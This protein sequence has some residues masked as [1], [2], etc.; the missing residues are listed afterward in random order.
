MANHYKTVQ[1]LISMVCLSVLVGPVLAQTV[2]DNKK[3]RANAAERNTARASEAE[4]LQAQR[5]TFATS[6]LTSLAD[7]ARSFNDLALRPRVLARAAD[8]LWDADSETARTLFRRAWEAAEKGDA[9]GVTLKTKDSPPPMVIALRRM[10]G[11]DLRS[12]VLGLVAGRD[13]ALAE[14]FLARL[15]ADAKRESE[16]LKSDATA[17]NTTDSWSGSEA[18]A[19]R[20]QMAGRLLDA[21][22]IERSLEFAA[23]VLGQ[24]NVNSISF[25]STLRAKEPGAAA[26]ADRW[27]AALLARAE[28]DP[29]SDANTVSGLSSYAFTPG[30][31]VTFMADGH[32]RWSQPEESAGPL[33]PPNLAPSLRNRFFQVAASI[34]LRPLPPPDQD[35]STSGYT[36]RY[37]II[38]RLLPLFDQFA[39][40]AALALRSQMN[41]LAGNAGT[42]AAGSDSSLLTKGLQPAGTADNAFE[43]MQY[44]LDHAKTTRERDSIYADAAA[45]LGS[46]G[47]ARAQDLAD[48]IDNSDRRAQLRRYV[49]FELVRFVIRKKEPSEVARLAKAGQLTHTQRAWAYVQAA[50]LLMNSE[51]AR[52][53]QFLEDAADEARRI[54]GDDADRA[55]LLISVATQFVRADHVRAW[56]IMS[57]AVEAANSAEGFT[58][59]NMQLRFPIATKDGVKISSIGGEEFALVGVL[60]SLTKED[61]DRSIDLAK[62][63]KNVAPR[64]NATLAIASA[65]LDKNAEVGFKLQAR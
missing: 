30:V 22:Q 49:D 60:R 12:E 15:T 9:E 37:M 18:S 21:G 23:P 29:S 47:D 38:K 20:L 51:R 53:L 64:A 3:L 11:Q 13:R 61:L 48:K 4:S 1:S 24:V 32:A 28:F 27:F 16:D 44:R 59:E 17:R 26:T 14:E 39:P 2:S 43:N 31:Y 54:K 7:E 55:C 42:T 6:L 25:L 58:G 52:A 8:T 10:S 34:L 50:R 45:L 57:E 62:S 19:K 46:Q 35:F 65:L 56:E 36:G 63:F 5:R 33:N 41:S 40:D